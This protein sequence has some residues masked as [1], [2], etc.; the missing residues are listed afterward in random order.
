MKLVKNLITGATDLFK[1]D[2]W[3]Q[4]LL[5]RTLF[6]KQGLTIYR[7][8]ELEVLIDHSGGD[9]NGTR[10]CITSGMYKQH[11]H[12]LSQ[13]SPLNV[14]DLGANGGGL[15]ISLIST[16]HRI[17]CYSGVEMNPATFQRLTFNVNRNCS[18]KNHLFNAAAWKE[19]TTLE[20]KL[21]NGGTADSVM[22]STDASKKTIVSAFTFDS[23]AEEVFKDEMIHLCKI[24]I[25]GAEHEMLSSEHCSYLKKV[26]LLIIEIH[27]H[28]TSNEAF[29]LNKLASHGLHPHGEPQREGNCSVWLLKNQSLST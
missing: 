8:N 20:V 6:R 28:I 15:F 18:D 22:G 3:L 2:N 12:H 17:A 14:F 23:V 25:E 4:L 9:Q 7:Y 13:S 26:H 19:N 10:A 24:D 11:F 27:P 16:N 29:I 1:F 21:G 5:N